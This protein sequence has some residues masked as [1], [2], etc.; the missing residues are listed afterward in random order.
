MTGSDGQHG[1][2]LAATLKRLPHFRLIDSRRLEKIAAH[3]RT[4]S[5]KS[6]DP[7]F[8]ERE[9]A[10]AFFVVIRGGVKLYRLSPD[11]RERVV[12]V[13]GPGHAFAEAAVLNFGFYP[14]NGV[15]TETPTEILEIPAEPI[16]KMMHEEEGFAGAMVG[17]LCMRLLE[18]VERVE[19][20]SSASAAARLARHLIKLPATGTPAQPVVMLPIAK[21]D[22]AAQ[23]G[24]APETLSRV[25]RQWEDLHLIE[26]NQRTIVLREPGRLLEIAEGEAS[27]GPA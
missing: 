25:L 4:R 7:I 24:I 17:S 13:L 22:L 15:A 1:E 12:H 18:L 19:E 14:V 26:S 3:A 9:P 2:R 21:K 5:C 11:G 16:Q 23:L 20:L 27:S 6:G 10:K 8:F